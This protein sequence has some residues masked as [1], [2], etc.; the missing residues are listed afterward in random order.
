MFATAGDH[1]IHVYDSKD[2]KQIWE[3]PLGAATTGAPSMYEMNG[4]QYLL[5]TASGGGGRGAARNTVDVAGAN[6]EGPVGI[7]AYALPK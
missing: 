5:V 4:R 3:T 2:G 6:P 1:K 7:V